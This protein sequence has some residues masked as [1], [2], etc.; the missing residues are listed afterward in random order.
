MSIAENVA[1]VRKRIAGAAERVGR[2]PEE[3]VLMAV[4]KTFPSQSIR[5]AY[6]AGLR[7]FGENRVQEF[8]RKADAM[9]DLVDVNWH[10]IGHLQTNKAAK[11]AESFDAVDSV[12][13]VRL[14]DKLNMSAN[15]ANKTLSILIEINVGGEAAKS[16]MVI[17]SDEL[18]EIL[19]SAPRWA[20]LRLR[21]LMTVPPYSEDPEGSRPYF[22]Q[23]RQIRDSIAN[24]KLPEVEMQVLS[25]GM[26]HDFE[27]AI[28]EGATCVRVGTAIF[29]KREKK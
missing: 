2:A 21:G 15:N 4:S 19:Q 7:V 10:L 28:E 9:C 25:M 18:E 20:N 5:E 8:A 17:G 27:V 6:T 23:F 13:S 12:D 16:G 26:S 22:R 3:I 14:A 29:G 1:E 24:R 11:A